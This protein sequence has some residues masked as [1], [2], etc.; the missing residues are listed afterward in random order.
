MEI[1][2]IVAFSTIFLSVL[3]SLKKPAGKTPEEEL[4]AAISKYLSQG[5]KV[6]IEK[7]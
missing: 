7:D 5:V 1:L 2:A 6:R 4:G 3:E